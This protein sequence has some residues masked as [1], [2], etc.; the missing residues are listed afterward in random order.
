MKK[1][2]TVMLI[3]VFCLTTA[4]SLL[5]RPEQ[6][7]TG[8]IVDARELKVDPS[9]APKVYDEGGN[10]IYGTMDVDPDYVIKVG[11]VQYENTIGDAIRDETAGDNP[12]VVRAI[13][14]GAHP[15]KS[16]VVVSD[17]DAK[18]IKKANERSLFL[19]KLKVVFII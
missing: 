12:I 13:R 1:I 16:D 15:Y 18:W 17:E 3:A 2:L 6:I 11:I 4:S 14:R 9:K 5:A 10:E 8:L 19:D 7:Y